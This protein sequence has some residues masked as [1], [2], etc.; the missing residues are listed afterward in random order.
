MSIA[1]ESMIE[2][3]NLHFKISQFDKSKHLKEREKEY[4]KANTL[5]HGFFVI[6]N[7]EEGWWRES[8][9]FKGDISKQMQK[10]NDDP[11]VSCAWVNQPRFTECGGW[12]DD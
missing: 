5:T 12:S 2:N 1:I 10:L 4:C 11:T 3:D 8:I 9:D 6:R 7:T